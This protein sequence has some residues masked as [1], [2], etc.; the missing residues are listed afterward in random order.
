MGEVKGMVV[1]MYVHNDALAR[2]TGMVGRRIAGH[3]HDDVAAYDVR[4][5]AG[6][7]WA[8]LASCRWHGGLSRRSCGCDGVPWAAAMKPCGMWALLFRRFHPVGKTFYLSPWLR[9]L[10]MAGG[11]LPVVPPQ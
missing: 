10:P 4:R 7:L 6:V 2:M 11:C 8:S 3:L 9:R 1:R 5:I